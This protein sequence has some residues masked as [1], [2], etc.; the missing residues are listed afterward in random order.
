MA[1][2]YTK[3]TLE[4]TKWCNRCSRKTRHAVSGNRIGH[5]LEC[6]KIKAEY[7]PGPPIE[8]QR[9]CE[10]KLYPFAHFHIESRPI[11]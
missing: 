11:P 6:G 3:N 2:H 1:Q 5:C 4:A 7:Q 10:C 8:L 9:P